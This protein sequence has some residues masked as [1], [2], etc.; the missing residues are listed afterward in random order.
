[1]V[2]KENID[3]LL[4]K[5][6]NLLIELAEYGVETTTQPHEK[7]DV[8]KDIRILE[9]FLE[10]LKKESP[11]TYVKTSEGLMLDDEEISYTRLREEQSSKDPEKTGI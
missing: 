3:K 5:R 8:E 6:L 7:K 1:M 2:A 11:K 4:D 9:Q 10:I